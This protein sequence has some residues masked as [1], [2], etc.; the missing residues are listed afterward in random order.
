MK[1]NER[2]ARRQAGSPGKGPKLPAVPAGNPTGR[3]AACK[4]LPLPAACSLL[5][6]LLWLGAALFTAAFDAVSYATGRLRTQTITLADTEYYTLYGL[7]RTGENALLSTD[8]DAQLMLTPGQPVRTLRLVARYSRDTCEKDLYYHLPGQGY[9][10]RLRVWPT[11]TGA[12]EYRYAVPLYAGQNLRLDLCDET[13]VEVT[14]LTIVLNEPQPLWRYFL[15]TP[16]QLFWLA[17]AAGLAA[18]ALALAAD[19]GSWRNRR[20]R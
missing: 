12:E 4:R 5:V 16:W 13:G 10:R 18:C 11:R 14:G 8:W 9:T 3:F 17:A 2:P 19:A 7:E 1:Q 15:P 6:I 20:R